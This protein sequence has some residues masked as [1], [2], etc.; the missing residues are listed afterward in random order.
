MILDRFGSRH[1]TASRPAVEA[2]E[3]AVTAVAAHRPSAADGLARALGHDADFVSAWALKGFAALML[4]R[5][6]LLAPAR[7]AHCGALAAFARHGRGT[8]G[9]AV[10]VRA[11]GV[12][13]DDRFHAAATLLEE[14]L[15]RHPADL[16]AVKI[17]QSLRFMGGDGAG[18]LAATSRLVPRWSPDMAGAG[19]VLGCHAFALEEAGRYAEAER[20]GREALRLEPGD[21]WG[22]HAVSHVH[23]MQGRLAEGIAGLEA[24]RPLWTACNNFRF[25][26]AWHLALFHLEDGRADRALA[27]YDAQVRPEPTDDYRDIANASSLLW[28]LR[29]DGVEVGGRWAELAEIGRRR[30]HETTVV[31]ASLHNLLALVGAGDR[32]GAHAILAALQERAAGGQGDQAQVAARV[33]VD[34]AR[35]VLGLSGPLR[36]DFARLARDLPLIGGSNAQRDVFMRTL[37]AMAPASAAATL[38]DLRRRL[39]REDSFSDRLRRRF[40]EPRH[41]VPRRRQHLALTVR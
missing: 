33:G 17:S 23:E 39:K 20:T 27:L 7:E 6:E 34:L 28:R 22:L 24:S 13:L 41:P 2:F 19:F 35:V 21:A 40:A 31:F 9:E 30:A 10:L 11:L 26:M 29:Q 14:H 12:A 8:P 5:A 3:A 25:H 16:L 32:C 38:L 15:D 37:V 18:M 36:A 4:G 1:T